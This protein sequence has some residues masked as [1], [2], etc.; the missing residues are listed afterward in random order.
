[1]AA[2]AKFVSYDGGIAFS[3]QVLKLQKRGQE[4]V[5]VPLDDVADVRVRRPQ[6][7]SE[8]FVRI[9][10]AD[11]QRYRIFF[12]DD[13]LQEAVQFKKQFDAAVSVE[14]DDFALEPVQPKQ[15]VDRKS[16]QGRES[17]TNALRCPNCGSTSV[18]VQMMQIAGKTKKHGAGLGGNINNAARGMT[19]MVT[20]GMSNLIW[21]KSEGTEKVK[22]TNQKVCVCQNCGNSWNIK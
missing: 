11:G 6:E 10:T 5:T 15:I 3:E 20:F 18:T 7:D 21:K 17:D 8:G 13:Q 4:S 19:A 9:E 1:M 14:E 16:R 12:E 2:I 22:Y